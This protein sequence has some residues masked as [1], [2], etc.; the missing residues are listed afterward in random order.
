MIDQSHV[1]D[2]ATNRQKALLRSLDSKTYE[3]IISDIVGVGDIELIKPLLA[4]ALGE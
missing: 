1:W 2:M 4:E 3:A